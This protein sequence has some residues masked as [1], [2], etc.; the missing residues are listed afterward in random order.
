MILNICGA[1]NERK[2]KKKKKKT[3]WSEICCGR[4]GV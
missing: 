1:T 4:L 2:K 3:G